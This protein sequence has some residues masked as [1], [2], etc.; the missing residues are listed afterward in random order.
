V[1]SN[2]STSTSTVG[3]GSQFAIDTN[4]LRLF[5]WWLDQSE[6]DRVDLDLS[7]LL[8]DHNW[9]FVEQVSWTNLRTGTDGYFAVHSGDITSAPAPDGASE[10]IDLYLDKL[11]NFKS[12]R[13]V[14]MT[15]TSFTG[16]KLNEITA[17]AGWMKRDDAI[18]GQIYEPQT[19]DT[20]FDL[21]TQSTVVAPMIVDIHANEIIW[22]D[23]SI[24]DNS[25]GCSTE[26]ERDAVATACE[27]VTRFKVTK[28]TMYDVFEANVMARGSDITLQD[29]TI[30]TIKKGGSVSPLDTAAFLSDWL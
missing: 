21:T 19:V 25:A 7:V 14:V 17:F 29:N 13:Y 2:T 28:T 30:F 11:R 27:A 24:N 3:R 16:Q 26:T 6:H 4:C 8:Y 20:K 12:T 10:F 1:P 22:A 5:C 15:V 23:M 9:Q 18:T